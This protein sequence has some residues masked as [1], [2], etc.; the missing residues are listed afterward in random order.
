ME[1]HSELSRYF[2]WLILLAVPLLVYGIVWVVYW[3]RRYWSNIIYEREVRFAEKLKGDVRTPILYLRNFSLDGCKI[4]LPEADFPNVKFKLNLPSLEARDINLNIEN[5]LRR[6]I[7]PLGLLISIG[8]TNP[9]DIGIN[10]VKVSDAQ[11]QTYVRKYMEQCQMIVLRTASALT[12]GV[13]WEMDIILANYLSKCLF[14]VENTSSPLTLELHKR[15]K[16]KF[17][18]HRPR[19]IQDFATPLY[20]SVSETGR[21]SYSYFVRHSKLYRALLKDSKLKN[22]EK[23]KRAQRFFDNPLQWYK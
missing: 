16:L 15:L 20:F 8:D 17:P 11:W 22:L 19:E 21:R 3:F 13:D 23:Q 5:N 10:R 1:S 2:W 7:F 9:A 6:K 18:N 12:P 14:F 4:N